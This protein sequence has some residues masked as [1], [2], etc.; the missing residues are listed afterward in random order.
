MRTLSAPAWKYRRSENGIQSRVLP[1][2]AAC[3]P[4]SLTTA[5]TAPPLVQRDVRDLA[6]EEFAARTAFAFQLGP[7]LAQVPHRHPAARPRHAQ[8][9]AFEARRR[10]ACLRPR[11]SR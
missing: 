2:R 4:S 7:I 8:G 6:G 3:T 10:P 11:H 9:G 1:A 5:R